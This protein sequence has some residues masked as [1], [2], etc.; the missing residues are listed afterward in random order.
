MLGSRKPH[1]ESAEGAAY[2]V[3]AQASGRI[4]RICHL[5]VPETN[6]MTPLIPAQESYSPETGLPLRIRGMVLP[7]LLK[8][9]K[10][11][12]LNATNKNSIGWAVAD[13][14]NQ[15][16]AVVGLGAQNERLLEGVTKLVEGREWFDTFTIDF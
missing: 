2:A 9:K 11:L 12:V 6:T 13:R 4:R 10:G 5:C 7:M 16:G 14:A 3:G 1:A 15:E 8:G